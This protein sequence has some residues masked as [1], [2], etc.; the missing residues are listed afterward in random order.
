M[1]LHFC[2]L[3]RILQ[4][5]G[6]NKSLSREIFSFLYESN[7]FSSVSRV[8]CD[9]KRQTAVGLAGSSAVAFWSPAYRTLALME[10]KTRIWNEICALIDIKWSISFDD[11]NLHSWQASLGIWCWHNQ[12]ILSVWKATSCLWSGRLYFLRV[13]VSMGFC[14]NCY[15]FSL[16]TCKNRKLVSTLCPVFIP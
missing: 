3:T 7:F 12:E 13:F 5:F 4:Y 14:Q 1:G 2:F 6:S 11:L 10:M 9:L 16:L 8:K 15:I